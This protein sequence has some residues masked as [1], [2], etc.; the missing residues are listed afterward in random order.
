MPD[1]NEHCLWS[2]IH[3]IKDDFFRKLSWSEVQHAIWISQE[4]AIFI[5]AIIEGV[6]RGREVPIDDLT[7]ANKMLKEGSRLD[8]EAC[9]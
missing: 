4:D 3:R 6:S 9:A 8:P 5:R 1:D 7:E 2:P